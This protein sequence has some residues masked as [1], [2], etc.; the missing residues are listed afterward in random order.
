MTGAVM[1]NR[2]KLL[3]VDD[4][5]LNRDF[6]Q[7]ILS[8]KYDVYTCGSVDNFYLLIKKIQFDLILMDVCLHDRKDGIELTRELRKDKRYYK[9]PVL[10]LTANNNRKT[11][12]DAIDAGANQF[13][14]KPCESKVVLN[15]VERYLTTIRLS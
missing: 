10:I 15:T 2:S 12:T 8:K 4:E 7:I 6:L 14:G 9:T 1:N 11:F 3:I 5:E 13:I